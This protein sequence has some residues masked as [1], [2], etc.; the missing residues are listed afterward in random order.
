M[1]RMGGHI[2]PALTKMMHLRYLPSINL[3]SIW[4]ENDVPNYAGE[5]VTEAETSNEYI[6]RRNEVLRRRNSRRR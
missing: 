2:F 6:R 5:L 4:I 3:F 1:Q